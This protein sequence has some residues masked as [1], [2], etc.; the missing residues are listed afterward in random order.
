[1]VGMV[2]N[3]STAG[4]AEEIAQLV[5]ALNVWG[6]EVQEN[7]EAAW[8]DQHREGRWESN[9]DELFWFQCA[10]EAISNATIHPCTNSHLFLKLM[11]LAAELTKV[12]CRRSVGYQLV[13]SMPDSKAVL[14]VLDQPIA[15]Q[16]YQ[17]WMCFK[18]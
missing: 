12:T 10:M 17:S 6:G 2:T 13:E 1:M 15:P 5:T 4:E 3:T 16:R 14:L 7:S 18:D 9:A 11:F 8:R